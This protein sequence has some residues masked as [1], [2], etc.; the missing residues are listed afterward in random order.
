MTGHGNPCWKSHTVRTVTRNGIQQIKNSFNKKYARYGWSGVY[1]DLLRKGYTRSCSGMIY[2]AKR[3]GQKEQTPKKKRKR[4][5]RRYP[6][7][8]VPGEKVQVMYKK[9][10]ITACKKK[11]QIYNGSRPKRTFGGKSPGFISWRENSGIISA[12][13]ERLPRSVALH[14]KVFHKTVALTFNIFV[15]SGHIY[16]QLRFHDKKT[17]K[18]C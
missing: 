8:L 4:T 11:H 15:K 3:L 2:A 1:E 14:S 18:K 9:F 10:R 6:E 7:L 12:F 17:N 5:A 16:L 13:F